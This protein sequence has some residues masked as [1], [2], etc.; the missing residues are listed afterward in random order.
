MYEQHFGLNK[1]PFPAKVRGNNVFVGPQTARTM[2]ALK[3]ALVAQDAV[4]AVSGP[5][6]S[7]K[8]TLIARALGALSETHKAVRIGRMHLAGEDALEYLLEELGVTDLP[9]GPIRQFA[10]LRTRLHEL[11]SENTRLVVVVE[12]AVRIGEETL[13]ELEAL[14]AADAGDGGGA[15]L[16]LMGDEQLEA[17]CNKP[18]LKRLAQ[19]VRQ[20]LSIEPLCAAELRGYLMHCFRLAGADFELVFDD[21]SAALVHHLSDGIPR[22]ANKIVEASLAAAAADG[23]DKVAAAFVA[24]VARNEFGLESG[25]FDLSPPRPV[26]TPD[27]EPAPA[28]EPD[29]E[30]AAEVREPVPDAESAVAVAD[31]ADEEMPVVDD[32]PELIQDTLPD[33]EV[34]APEIMAADSSAEAQPDIPELQPADDAAP[35]IDDIPEL[36]PFE[37]ADLAAAAIGAPTAEPAPQP[38]S[39]AEAEP[40]PEP[41]PVAAEQAN[42]D[43]DIPDWD[44]DPTLAELRPDLDALEKAMAFAHGEGDAGDPAP[45]PGSEASPVPEA[46][47]PEKS[48]EEIPEITLDNAIKERVVDNLIDEPGEVSPPAASTDS[49]PPGDIDIPAVDVAPQKGE[50]ADSEIERIAAELRRAKTIEDVDD[51]LAETLFGEEINL[52]AAHVVASGAAPESAND[53]ELALFD[54]AAESIAQ[55]AGTPQPAAAA[56]EASDVEV[57][58]ETREHGGESGLDLSAS[59]RLKTVRALNADLHP[60]L[61]EPGNDGPDPMS[62]EAPVPNVPPEPIEDQINTSI[63]QTLKVLNVTTPHS[64]IAG[65]DDDESDNKKS[66]F[67]SR[68]KRS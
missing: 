49:P 12:D 32:I 21:R 53:E 58:L 8:T 7:G 5:A 64:G 39:A 23:V 44:R 65:L 56:V 29:P 27:P 18:Q 13:A 30:P 51:K 54:T 1:Q 60:S 55:T 31:K 14:T 4:V 45:V 24:N 67:F 52:I 2:A 41:E 16:V 48:V 47:E 17:F 11:E 35:D 36:E 63:T 46:V 38:E 62:N 19:R 42:N 68:F 66:G 57:S 34:L 15:A 50:N 26:A 43:D 61:R 20:R 33:L 25:D 40:E 6:G 9:R 28:P 59:Q 10:A 3:K 37:S 22:V